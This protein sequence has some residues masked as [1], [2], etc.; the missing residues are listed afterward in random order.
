[1]KIDPTRFLLLTGVFTA[2][3][4]M[5]VVA[6]CGSKSDSGPA[7]EKTDG[8]PPSAVPPTPPP[9]T[10]PPPP[11]PSAQDSGT[12]DSG[13]AGKDADAGPACLDD[14]TPTVQP[15]CPGAGAG[16][17]CD[18]ACADFATDF[19]K[20]L[21]ADIRKCLTVAICLADTTTCADK[22]LAK[23][24]ADATATTFCTTQVTGCKAVN[25]AD[26]ITQ[27]SCEAIAKGLTTAGRAALQTC[28]E[29]ENNCGDCPA[30]AKQK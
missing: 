6:G 27:A 22:A 26:T 11:P 3:I 20:G 25:V 1:M 19:K 4:G 12:K 24:C 15:A 13:D 10:P 17:E 30:K 29:T 8:S 2:S 18:T 28:F 23:A 16:G 9:A 21:S 14:L 5:F 7:A